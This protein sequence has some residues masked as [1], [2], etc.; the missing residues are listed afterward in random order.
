MHRIVNDAAL[1]A[2]FRA[3]RSP[4][5]WAAQSVGDTLL[6]AVWEL[7]KLGPT[8]GA[9]GGARILFV[10]SDA[11]KDR[12]ATA[13]PA[14]Q[15]AIIAA[16]ATA[17][18]GRAAGDRGPAA[19]QGGTQAAYLMLAARALG[20]DCAP[21]WEFDAAAVGAAFYPGGTVAVD[22]LCSLGYGDD[23]QRSPPAILPA[24]DEACA[25]L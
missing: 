12:L 21:I 4:D 18:L 5:A 23:A 8:G 6:L 20:L 9:G 13:L 19:A 1:D 16:P 14:A 17:I 7:V 11:A 15:A 24:S 22:F 3:A 2:L 25:I 10:K